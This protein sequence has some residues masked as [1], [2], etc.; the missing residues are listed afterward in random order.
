[1]IDSDTGDIHLP[2]GYV[3]TPALTL[4][5]FR[6]IMVWTVRPHQ[7]A[8]LHAGVIAGSLEDA[9]IIRFGSA[10]S[11]LSFQGQTLTSDLLDI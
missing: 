1:M 6:Q 4:D 3:I 5:E 11:E 8:T 7:S 9:G 2:N 10:N